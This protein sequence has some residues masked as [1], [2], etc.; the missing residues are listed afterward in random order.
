M[1]ES[2]GKGSQTAWCSYE[3]RPF[4]AGFGW[5]SVIIIFLGQLFGH[6]MPLVVSIF[7]A[8]RTGSQK[9]MC[10]QQKLNKRHR[11]AHSFASFYC[12]LCLGLGCPMTNVYSSGLSLRISWATAPFFSGVESLL[13]VLFFCLNIPKFKCPWWV[14]SPCLVGYITYRW[15]V[16]G[17]T[18]LWN[19]LNLFSKTLHEF[20]LLSRRSWRWPKKPQKLMRFGNP[21]PWPVSLAMWCDIWPTID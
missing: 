19:A 9:P 11:P 10:Q 15:M 1:F 8:S 3:D 16:D 12:Q 14:L 18:Y 20:R 6:P 4:L 13:F 2:F 17:S 21:S 5:H 7:I